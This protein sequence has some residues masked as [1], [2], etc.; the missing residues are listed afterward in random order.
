MTPS[1]S[2]G[3]AGPTTT[4]SSSSPSGIP[5]RRIFQL[6][7]NYRSTP[8]IVAFTKASIAHNTSGFP[9]E[10]VSARPDGTLPLVVADRGRL[11]R[12]RVHL[13]ADPRSAWKGRVSAADGRALSQPPRQH[14][15]AGRAARSRHSLYGPQRASL[16]RAGPHQGRAGAPADRRQPAR[17]SLVAP[18]ALAL[19]RDR[20]GQ[21]R[22]R[23]FSTCRRAAGRSRRSNRPRRWH[24]CRPRARASS[25]GS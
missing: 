23:S 4:T 15:A 25:R 1:R 20:S 7:V 5:V 16:L 19:A 9:K 12:G 2:T 17:R 10:L 14:P 21:G 22:R 24:S 3:S 11:R 18:A 13:P 6:E 8:Q